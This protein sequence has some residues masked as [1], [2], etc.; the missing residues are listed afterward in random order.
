MFCLL[1]RKHDAVNLQKSRKFNSEAAIRYKRKAVQE[2]S[3]SQQHRA[4]VNAELQ[5]RVSVFHVE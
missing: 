5:S 3:T 4:A 2:H 1:C